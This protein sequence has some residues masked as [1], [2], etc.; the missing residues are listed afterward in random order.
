MSTSV[1][2]VEVE[3]QKRLRLHRRIQ[4][5]FNQMWQDVAFAQ[6]QV[7]NIFRMYEID[8]TP[9]EDPSGGS[10][11]RVVT[12]PDRVPTDLQNLFVDAEPVAL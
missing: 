11:W 12:A 6:L 8:G 7:G 10:S 4:V 3:N 9:V 5:W 2:E 1:G